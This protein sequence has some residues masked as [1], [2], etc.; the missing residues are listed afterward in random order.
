VPSPEVA[1]AGSSGDPQHAPGSEQALVA[2]DP[3]SSG[4]GP[5]G[6]SGGQAAASGGP[7]GASGVE[8]AGDDGQPDTSNPAAA[9]AAVSTEGGAEVQPSAQ[10]QADPDGGQTGLEQ[11]G[12]EQ[13]GQAGPAQ[14]AQ[15]GPG[16]VTQA[17]PVQVV[18]L[19]SIQVVRSGPVQVT[20]TEQAEPGQA[21]PGQTEA[22]QT[23]PGQA[24]PGQTEAGQTEA[25]PAGQAELGQAGQTEAGQTEAG[26]AGQAELGQAGQAERGQAPADGEQAGTRDVVLTLQRHLLPAGVPV[27]P[28]AQLAA[29]HLTGTERPGDGC[30]DVFTLP[31]GTVALMTGHAAGDGPAAVAAMSQLRTV[32]RETLLAG[33]GLDE[34]LPRMDVIA[35]LAPAAAGA[36]VGI[37]LLDP[38]TGSLHYASAG[39][40]A[41]LVCAPAGTAAALVPGGGGPLGM[42][43]GRPPPTRAVLPPGSVLVLG[44]G[45]NGAP[46]G[47]D[48]GERLAGAVTAALAGEGALEAGSAGRICGNV[49][50]G[51]TRPADGDVTVLAAHRWARPVPGFSLRL[52]GEPAALRRLRR[53]LAQ[54]LDGLGVAATDRMDTELAVYEAAANAIVH[55]RPRQGE[56]VVTVQA[57]LD[58][59]GGVLVEVTDR[60]RWRVS[61]EDLDQLRPG[62]RGLS[63]ISKVTEELTITA[64]AIG[65]TVVMR[66]RLSQ[67]VRLAP[68]EQ[69]PAEQAPAA[70]GA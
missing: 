19:G 6:T 46:P 4:G 35:D 32:L 25:G 40:P 30:F 68:A 49:A 39:Q 65:T 9:V 10:G 47:R 52:P 51:L 22:G 38:V 54:W 2:G 41:P 36:S 11:T 34:A 14:A 33:A 53:R 28:T 21:E 67:P 42:A 18:R 26:P 50:E 20:Q 27:F 15:G 63:V 70:G 3:G 7:A 23:E 5:A 13:T 12:P 45:G 64:S 48:T 55:G 66:R 56:A 60:G 44:S 62:G 16:Q 59:I 29:W 37:G 1:D 61:G 43:G 17:G 8:I 58:G 57:R 69:A 24:E 31:S